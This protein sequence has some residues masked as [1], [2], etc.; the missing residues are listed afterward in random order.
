MAL[1]TGG[2][3]RSEG[4]SS[5]RAAQVARSNTQSRPEMVHGVAKKL[6]HSAGEAAGAEGAAGGSKLIEPDYHRIGQFKPVGWPNRKAFGQFI[7]L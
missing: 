6:L 1:T 3:K 5:G 4:V 2:R 7:K